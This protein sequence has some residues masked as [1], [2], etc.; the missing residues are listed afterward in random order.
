[1]N[2]AMPLIALHTHTTK[3]TPQPQV[4]AAKRAKGL[5]TQLTQYPGMAH[6]FALRGD[7]NEPAVKAASTGA[8]EKGAAFLAKYLK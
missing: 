4:F 3:H 6:G 8:F 5:D 1:M 2:P 7:S